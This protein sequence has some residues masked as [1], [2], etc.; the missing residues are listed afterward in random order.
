M[1]LLNLNIGR[2]KQDLEPQKSQRT[3]GER[4]AGLAYSPGSFP[5]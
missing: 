4:A 5:G 3:R 1:Y 2:A